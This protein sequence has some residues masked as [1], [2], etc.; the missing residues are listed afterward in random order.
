M[1]VRTLLSPQWLWRHLL[2]VVLVVSFAYLGRWQWD[3]AMAATGDIQNLL[4]AIEWWTFAGLVVFGWYRLMR[5]DVRDLR[6]A[7]AGLA[8]AEAA[9]D[10]EAGLPAFARRREPVPAPVEDPAEEADL[11]AYNA[12]LAYLHEHPRR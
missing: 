2:V 1:S 7:R 3:R 9:P 12:Y 11:A 4:Y 8:V 5:D 6:A 10:P